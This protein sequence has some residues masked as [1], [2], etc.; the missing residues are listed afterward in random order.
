MLN[1]GLPVPA[2]RSTDLFNQLLSRYTI[3]R[4]TFLFVSRKLFARFVKRSLRREISSSIPVTA[5]RDN[6]PF[7][8]YFPF[9]TLSHFSFPLFRFS[10]DQLFSSRNKVYVSTWDFTSISQTWRQRV[11]TESS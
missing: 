1:H 4:A 6:F 10:S 3:H 11:I 8:P 7:F 9:S 5:N 2:A